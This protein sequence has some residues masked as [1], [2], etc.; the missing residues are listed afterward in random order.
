MFRVTPDV[1]I[2][3]PETEWLIEQALTH[4]KGGPSH[5]V[6]ADVGTGSG[7]LA[8]TIALEWPDAIVVATD[9]SARA[10]DVAM[11]N[12]AALGAADRTRFVETEFLDERPASVYLVVANL[13]YV[14]DGDRPTLAPDVASYEP[15][16]ALFG[17]PEGLDAIAAL[18]PIAATAL[19]PGGWLLM[20]IGAG[21]LAGIERLVNG[22]TDFS[23]A[24]VTPD[25]QGI[26]RVVTLQR[27]SSR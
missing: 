22:I 19:A 5:P 6:I 10:L 23:L 26:P 12:A 21:Q 7:C 18:L 15:A 13:P 9:R 8:V 16:S 2:P 4:R 3:R 24:S 1:L 17:G 11:D 27:R 25:L 14:P 20:E